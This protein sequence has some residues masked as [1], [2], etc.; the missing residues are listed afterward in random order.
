MVFSDFLARVFSFISLFS[1]FRCLYLVFCVLAFTN[2][3]QARGASDLREGMLA[4]EAHKR[5]SK[6][7]WTPDPSAH[8]RA[9]PLWGLEKRLFERG[10]TAVDRCAVDRP[11]CILKY[12]RA[13]ACLEV[14]IEG[15][16]ARYMRVVGWVRECEPGR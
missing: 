10:M 14:E 12:R 7:R 3:A 6:S 8:S 16:D 9:A 11:V 2:L 5:V 13:K 1:V 15:E 4:F